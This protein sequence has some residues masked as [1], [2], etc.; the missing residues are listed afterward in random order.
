MAVAML[1]LLET[2]EP[3]RIRAMVRQSCGEDHLDA[4]DHSAAVVGGITA[5]SKAG[6]AW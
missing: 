1:H 5:L 3:G 4:R 6:A 2:Y